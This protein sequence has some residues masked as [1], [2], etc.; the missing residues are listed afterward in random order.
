MQ[1]VVVLRRKLILLGGILHSKCCVNAAAIA[2]TTPHIRAPPSTEAW[3]YSTVNTA[4][5]SEHVMK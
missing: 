2:A 5:C 3:R 1:H 4:M